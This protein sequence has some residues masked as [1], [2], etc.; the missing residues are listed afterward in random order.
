MTDR[1]PLNELP[2]HSEW[3]RYLLAEDRDPPSEP[4]T[5]IRRETYDDMYTRLYER[6]GGQAAPPRRIVEEIRSGDPDTTHVVSR[7]ETLSVVDPTELVRREYRTVRAALD[8]IAE[9]G[10]TVYDL[11]CGWGWTLDAIASAFPDVRVVGGEPVAAGVDFARDLVADRDRISVHQFDLLGDWEL[12]DGADA[13]GI[14]FTKGVLITLPDLEP[15]RNQVSEL[16]A[17]GTLKAG[18]HLEQTGPHPETVLGYL[19]RRY[20]RERG[21]RTDVLE[22]LRST[23]TIEVTD[24]SYDVHGKNPLHPLTRI[25]WDGRTARPAVTR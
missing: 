21:Y 13:D 5:Y 20:S 8:P 12:F 1:L 17:A 11:G 9:P 10:D 25:R 15:V 18:V 7:K 4:E 22:G 3:A 16:V 23:S 6:H 14:L 2:A 19:R 24:V